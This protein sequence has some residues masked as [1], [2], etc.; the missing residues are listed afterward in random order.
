MYITVVGLE[1]AQISAE[2]E[3][4]TDGGRIDIDSDSAPEII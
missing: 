1:D 3:P 2:L 4:W